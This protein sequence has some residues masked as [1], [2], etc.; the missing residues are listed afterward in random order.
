[1]TPNETPTGKLKQ[2][3]VGDLGV[4]RRHLQ[5]IDQGLLEPTPAVMREIRSSIETCIARIERDVGLLEDEVLQL[6][7]ALNTSDGAWAP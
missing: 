3:L 2:F 7:N 5:R 4:A 1:M 6:R